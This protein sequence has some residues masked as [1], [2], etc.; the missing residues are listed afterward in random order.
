MII[1][2]IV[3]LSTT[4][5]LFSMNTGKNIWIIKDISTELTVVGMFASLSEILYLLLQNISSTYS[6]YIYD[7]NTGK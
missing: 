6:F 1:I 5:Q 2:A 4:I 7:L 3:N